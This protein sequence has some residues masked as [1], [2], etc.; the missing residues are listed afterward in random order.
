MLG[1]ILGGLLLLQM[2]NICASNL[3]ALLS[4]ILA[5]GNWCHEWCQAYR[6]DRYVRLSSCM[7]AFGNECWL[8]LA[9]SD[10]A[11]DTA[12]DMTC[13]MACDRIPV[14]WQ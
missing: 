1:A 4:L 3:A 13:D 11:C 6:I 10:P 8:L 9:A 12:R 7:G 5:N 2:L 14:R